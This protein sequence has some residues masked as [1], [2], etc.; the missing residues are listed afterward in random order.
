MLDTK[1][2]K[3]LENLPYGALEPVV[4]TDSMTGTAGEKLMDSCA[5]ELLTVAGSIRDCLAKITN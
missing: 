3:W 4:A 2:Q 5:E 1:R